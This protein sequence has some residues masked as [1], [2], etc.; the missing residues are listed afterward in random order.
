MELSDWEGYNKDNAKTWA[1]KSFGFEIEATIGFPIPREKED[2]KTYT[3]LT[4]PKLYKKTFNK[5]NK[6]PYDN[7][8]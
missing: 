3:E 6:E 8:N 2:V 5:L 7:T 1:G 4:F